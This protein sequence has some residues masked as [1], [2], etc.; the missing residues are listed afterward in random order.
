[1]N[2]QVREVV[3]C[4][5]GAFG[6]AV[7][8]GAVAF[9]LILIMGLQNT[10]GRSLAV[11]LTILILMMTVLLVALRYMRLATI[12]DD[13]EIWMRSEWCTHRLRTE[14]IVAIDTCILRRYPTWY[15]IQITDTDGHVVIPFQPR[16]L[17]RELA[18]SDAAKLRQRLGERS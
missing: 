15:G 14:H 8:A 16:Y 13:A 12:A 6:R 2:N 11:T 18:E 3:V 1:M 9:E 10:F 7:A 17:R 5:N 4:R